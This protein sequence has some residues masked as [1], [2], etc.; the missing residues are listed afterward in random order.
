MRMRSNARVQSVI[1]AIGIV[2]AVA[3]YPGGRVKAQTASQP[4]EQADNQPPAQTD[5]QLLS[6]LAVQV[7]CG[8]TTSTAGVPEH[9]LHVIGG[10]DTAGRSLFSE[11]D[12][13]VIDGGTDAGLQLGQE[14]FVRRP[15][16][17][18]GA[19]G[20]GPLATYGARSTATFA[21]MHHG[22]ISTRRETVVETVGWVRVVALNAT[23]GLAQIEHACQA[24]NVQDYLE[25]FA[26]PQ[27]PADGD[28]DLAAGAVGSGDFDFTALGHI[29]YGN[30]FRETAG[31]GDMMLIDRGTEQGVTLG[32]RMAIFRDLGSDGLP[33]SAVGETIVVAVGDARSLARISRARDAV[34]SGDFVVP[35][36]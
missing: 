20:T 13:L 17:P 1:A 27:V 33:L 12:L 25:P 8:P 2:S 31:V 19:Y 24:L 14:F 15:M 23:T 32:A 36:R 18:G 16:A 28:R 6:P 7:A 22:T 9:P 4:P 10:D 21:L 30:G 34:R 5:D 11:R 3:L 29:L 26:V 35:R